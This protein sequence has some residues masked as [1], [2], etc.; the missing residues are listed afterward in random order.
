MFAKPLYTRNK[1]YERIPTAA[2]FGHTVTRG[3]ALYT[4]DNEITRPGQ[5]E[6]HGRWGQT[7]RGRAKN[8]IPTSGRYKTS[9]LFSLGIQFWANILA[10]FKFCLENWFARTCFGKYYFSISCDQNVSQSVPAPAAVGGEKSSIVD[11]IDVDTKSRSNANGICSLTRFSAG[12]GP[13]LFQQ[14]CKLRLNGSSDHR[15]ALEDT[16]VGMIVNGVTLTRVHACTHTL[17]VVDS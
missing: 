4:P 13:S 16:D 6:R 12:C 9:G 17:L 1:P 3:S 10:C 7:W 15:T 14:V 2:A 5:P 8:V 11:I